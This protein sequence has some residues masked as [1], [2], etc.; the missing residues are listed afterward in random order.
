MSLRWTASGQGCAPT[1]FADILA[2][3]QA[4]EVAAAAPL[5]GRVAIETETFGRFVGWDTVALRRHHVH[6]DEAVRLAHVL[7][8]SGCAAYGGGCCF[9]CKA[10]DSRGYEPSKSRPRTHDDKYGRPAEPRWLIH[11]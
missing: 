5:E 2:T 4:I 1:T 9:I 6:L 3:G 7:E 11:G 10:A 8:V